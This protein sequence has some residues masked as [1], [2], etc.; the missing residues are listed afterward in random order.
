MRPKITLLD[1]QIFPI[2][3]WRCTKWAFGKSLARQIDAIQSSMVC[4]LAKITPEPEESVEGFGRRRAAVVRGAVGARTWAK[5][6]AERIC[7]WHQHVGRAHDEH[8]PA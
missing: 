8:S 7:T 6:T 5:A 1:K 3:Q 2:L 4:C